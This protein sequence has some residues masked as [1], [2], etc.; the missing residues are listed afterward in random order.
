MEDEA[1]G[2]TTTKAIITKVEI[3]KIS[4]VIPVEKL[5]NPKHADDWA[6]IVHAENDFTSV[7]SIPFWI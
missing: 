2:R 4:E 7:L 5:Q 3:K 6:I 1:V